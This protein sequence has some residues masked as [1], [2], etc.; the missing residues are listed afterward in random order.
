MLRFE[1]NWE[2]L[3]LQ[4]STG[5]GRLHRIL[6]GIYRHRNAVEVLIGKREY[7]VF[8]IGFQIP[9]IYSSLASFNSDLGAS[10]KLSSFG[11]LNRLSRQA[12]A[13]CKPRSFRI[14]ENSSFTGSGAAFNMTSRFN[15]FVSA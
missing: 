6:R 12:I 13:A 9:F 3:Q 14:F 4:F 5:Q 8:Y 10:M 15:E 11:Y 2:M 7:Y 1:A